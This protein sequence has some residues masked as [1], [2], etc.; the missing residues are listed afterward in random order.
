VIRKRYVGVPPLA[1]NLMRPFIRRPEVTSIVKLA[2]DDVP[3]LWSA[4]TSPQI[5]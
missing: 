2:F 1:V 5:G 4:P 3:R